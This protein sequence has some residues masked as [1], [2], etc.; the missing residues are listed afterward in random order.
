MPTLDEVLGN[1]K[2]SSFAANAATGVQV[3]S[4]DQELVFDLYVRT[5]LPADGFVFYVK[6]S[7]LSR[8]ALVGALKLNSVNLNQAGKILSGASNSITVSGSF[9]YN[10]VKRQ[11]EA[12]EYT[13]VE[14][15]FT[16][17][18]EV[19][20]LR[21]VA[22]GTAY[23]CTSKGMTFAFGSQG[24]FYKKADLFHYRGTAVYSDLLTQVVDNVGLANL[25]SQVV[26]NSL[27]IWLGFN[28]YKTFYG[29]KSAGV[30]LSPSMQLPFNLAPPFGSVHVLPETTQGVA[31]APRLSPDMSHSQFCSETVR[32]TFS[33]VRNNEALDFMDFVNQFTLDTEAFGLRNI[34]TIR[35]EKARTQPELG[36]SA[37]RK[38]AM[39][40]IN[41][42]QHRARQMSRQLIKTVIPSYII[43][44]N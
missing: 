11:E 31:S 28:S 4:D 14:A 21:D 22:P 1:P 2:N 12:L 18:T 42:H 7:M 39:F 15:V 37:Q 20:D 3:L 29:F 26:S 10:A 40:E 13:A 23:I 32:V 16:S 27:P 34:P 35:D 5:V 8:S 25:S 36:I 17:L 9:H 33:G 6:A 41:Y 19:N 38:T 30:P 44:P 43:P 24:Y